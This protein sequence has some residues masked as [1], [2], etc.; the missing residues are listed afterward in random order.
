MYNHYGQFINKLRRKCIP[1]KSKIGN[2][3]NDNNDNNNN[4]NNNND[5]N[6]NDNQKKNKQV[7]K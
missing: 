2:H 7:Y 6:D 5:N 3:A 1:V 4:S